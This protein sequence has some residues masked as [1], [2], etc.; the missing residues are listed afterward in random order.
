M[1]EMKD[2]ILSQFSYKDVE[3]LLNHYSYYKQFGEGE[4]KY[5]VLCMISREINKKLP[6]HIKP[7][8]KTEKYVMEVFPQLI[9]EKRT[10]DFTVVC[11]Y[12][13][14]INR[15]RVYAIENLRQND[16]KLLMENSIGIEEIHGLTNEEIEFIINGTE[17]KGRAEYDID[18]IHNLYE[19]KPI[20]EGICVIGQSKQMKNFVFQTNIGKIS[21]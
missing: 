19:S 13:K 8:L 3:E 6:D 10:K 15:H 5:V 12:V 18:L 21:I 4:D 1:E 20:E 17:I 16:Y 7:S 14:E 2:F 11:K 9:Q